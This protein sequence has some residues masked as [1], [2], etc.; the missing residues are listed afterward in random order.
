M[1][2][3]SCLLCSLFTSSP[4]LAPLESHSRGTGAALGT[5]ICSQL[6]RGR[7]QTHGW[8]YLLLTM[9][10]G[11]QQQRKEE[12][13]G[14]TSK[15]ITPKTGQTVPTP[16]QVTGVSSSQEVLGGTGSDRTHCHLSGGAKLQRLWGRKN[17]FILTKCKARCVYQRGVMLYPHP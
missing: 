4:A 10:G 8:N 5:R 9:S 15:D 11:T 17:H 2:A 7:R 3:P 6:A 13:T 1:E 14:N 12:W 16:C